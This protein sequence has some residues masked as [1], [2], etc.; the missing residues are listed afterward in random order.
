MG[1]SKCNTHNDE[2][3]MGW[4]WVGMWEGGGKGVGW[5]GGGLTNG[6]AVPLFYI[7]K[8]LTQF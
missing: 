5:G 1:H 4:I 8:V 6:C 2:I 7:P 3:G